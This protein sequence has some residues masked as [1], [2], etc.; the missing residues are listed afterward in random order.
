[1]AYVIFNLSISKESIDRLRQWHL[2]LH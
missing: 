1:M 2:H